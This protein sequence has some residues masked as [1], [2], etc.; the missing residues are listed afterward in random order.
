VPFYKNYYVGGIG[1]VRGYEQ[2]SIG[3]RDPEDPDDALGGT[4]KLVG[5]AEFFFPLPGAG[6][7]RSFR[8][9]AFVDAGYVWGEDDDIRADDLRYSTGLAFSWSSPIGP[10][11][12]SLGYPLNKKEDDQ[13]ENFQFQLGSVF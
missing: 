13:E 7:D 1:S 2:S 10:L 8:M 11:K 5:N 4:R 9:S 6:M 3:P 12:F